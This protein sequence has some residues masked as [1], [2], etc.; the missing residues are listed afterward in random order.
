MPRTGSLPAAAARGPGAISAAD[1][2]RYLTEDHDRIAERMNN[3][4]IHRIYSAG[5]TLQ[6]ALGLLRDQ[7]GTLEISQAVSELD[8][9][10]HDI[11]D[12]V[13][14]LGSPAR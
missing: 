4:V 5:L 12:I 9:A 6:V 13:F 14:D 2:T 11:R 1:V 3:V 8:H 10:I 7:P